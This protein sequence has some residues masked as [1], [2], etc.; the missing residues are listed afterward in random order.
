MI[1]VR[2]REQ[3]QVTILAWPTRKLPIAMTRDKVGYRG[4]PEGG[5]SVGNT[6]RGDSNAEGR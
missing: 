4:R 5:Q 2:L 6:A 1:A 3:F